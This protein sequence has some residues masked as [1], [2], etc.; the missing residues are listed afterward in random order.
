MF[1][2]AGKPISPY[3]QVRLDHPQLLQANALARVCRDHGMTRDSFLRECLEPK[4][5][6]RL[7]RFAPITEQEIRLTIKW[8]LKDGMTLD[9]GWVKRWDSFARNRP[10]LETYSSLRERLKNLGIEFGVTVFEI[11]LELGLPYRQPAKKVAPDLTDEIERKQTLL[12]GAFSTNDLAE[13]GY[14]RQRL[15]RLRGDGQ[16]FHL[17]VPKDSKFFYPGWQFDGDMEPHPFAREA[18]L[19][20]R[21]LD[22]STWELEMAMNT[23]VD[24]RSK[25]VKLKDIVPLT[26]SQEWLLAHLRYRIVA[27]SRKA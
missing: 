16:I 23:V 10:Y 19:L 11:A 24:Y 17:T 8:A 9:A 7:G 12:E 22:I 15:I 21:E 6:L 2:K 14:H 25:R 5:A 3:D 13:S 1:R 27:N 18:I 26:G 20:K 4:R